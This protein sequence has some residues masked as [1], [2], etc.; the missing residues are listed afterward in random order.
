M[1]RLVALGLWAALLV[2]TTAVPVRADDAGDGAR[3][4]SGTAAGGRVVGIGGPETMILR[5]G[6]RETYHAAAVFDAVEGETYTVF[7]NAEDG[8]GRDIDGATREGTVTRSGRITVTA[9]LLLCGQLHDAGVGRI[10]VGMLIGD[11]PAV[12]LRKRVVLKYDDA[13]SMSKPV[14][15]AGGQRVRLRGAWSRG[16]GFGPGLTTYIRTSVRVGLYFRPSGGRWER[17]ASTGIGTQGTWSK[18]VR[19]PKAGAWQARVAGSDRLL[20]ARSQVRRVG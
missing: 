5:S 18:R 13:V 9:P 16:R 1:K 2:G 15:V 8:T 4:E 12:D 6:C 14:R 19:L 11:D 17:V 20:P 10:K 7:L 3:E